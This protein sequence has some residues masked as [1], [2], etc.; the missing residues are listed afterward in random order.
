MSL[1]LG[2]ANYNCTPNDPWYAGRRA[3]GLSTTSRRGKPDL[4]QRRLLAS[5]AFLE[6]VFAATLRSKLSIRTLRRHAWTGWS[7]AAQL[8]GFSE[9]VQPVTRALPTCHCTKLCP[10]V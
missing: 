4:L 1:I 2:L 8:H 9:H 7:Y 5:D 6:L 3:S 10:Y